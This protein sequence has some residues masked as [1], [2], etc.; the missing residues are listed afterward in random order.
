M[1][2]EAN[3]EDHQLTKEKE[4]VPGAL[5]KPSLLAIEIF[6]ICDATFQQN[7]EL[8]ESSGRIDELAKDM[9]KFVKSKFTVP[10][11]HL[12]IILRRWFKVR[13]YVHASKL[14]YEMKRAKARKFKGAA[15]ASKTAKKKR[16]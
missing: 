7:L 10:E 1:T 9:E 13:M 14:N 16:S 4:F 6:S 12:G 2:S 5:T 15:N 3:L 11:C 8:L